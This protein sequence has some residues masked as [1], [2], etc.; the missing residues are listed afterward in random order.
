[1]TTWIVGIEQT[2][3]Y[4]FVQL[5]VFEEERD[6]LDFAGT[7]ALG[8]GG[9]QLSKRRWRMPEEGHVLTVSSRKNSIVLI[10]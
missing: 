5:E 2:K 1:M 10:N 7:Y 6:A 9:I 4:E 8:R 3:P